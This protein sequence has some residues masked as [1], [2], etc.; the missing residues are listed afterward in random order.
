MM[1]P[2]CDCGKSERASECLSRF[3]S[4]SSSW[5]LA[6]FHVFGYPQLVAGVYSTQSLLASFG[7]LRREE[8][9]V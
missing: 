5:K 3:T 4:S 2:T 6:A 1:A 9:E 8:N 7:L